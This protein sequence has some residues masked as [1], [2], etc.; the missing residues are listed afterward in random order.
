MQKAI[1]IGASSGI[2]RELAKLLSQEGYEVGLTGRRTELL[3]TLQKELSSKSYSYN[4]SKAYMSNFLEGLR[5]TFLKEGSNIFVT[6][7]KPGYVDTGMPKGDVFW[8][9]STKKAASQ[10]MDAIRA[11][12][13]RVYITKRWRI[14]AWLLMTMPDWFLI[15]FF[16]LG[17]RTNSKSRR[18]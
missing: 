12:K 17:K 15:C 3:L 14:I 5:Y 6:D 1:V 18:K 4:A 8:M 7:V 2:G 9:A 13:K 16:G 10:I 11:K